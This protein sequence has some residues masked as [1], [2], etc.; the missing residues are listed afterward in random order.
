MAV[1]ITK[2]GLII[3]DKV[4]SLE[5]L[6]KMYASRQNMITKFTAQQVILQKQID[7]VVAAK[8]AG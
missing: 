6:E 1:T 7:D 4:I 2:D 5:Q 3:N 8:I